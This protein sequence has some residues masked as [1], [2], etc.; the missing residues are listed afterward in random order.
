MVRS[1]SRPRAAAK[2]STLMRTRS[3]SAPD[4]TSRSMAAAVAT[5]AD[6]RSAAKR[7]WVSLTRASLCEKE[8]LRAPCRH[9]PTW[10]PHRRPPAYVITAPT[11]ML[12]RCAGLPQTGY[13]EIPPKQRPENRYRSMTHLGAVNVWHDAGSNGGC[14]AETR[15]SLRPRI[16]RQAG[17][18]E[19]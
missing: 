11:G 4:L 1:S 6:S 7:A 18:R 12:D 14:H 8:G 3:R 19:P 2:A 13:T 5:S 17:D 10:L 15:R 16:D 9:N